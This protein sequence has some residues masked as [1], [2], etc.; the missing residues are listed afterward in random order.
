MHHHVSDVF[1]TG[2]LMALNNDCLRG[3]NKAAVLIVKFLTP[4]WLGLTIRP[5]GGQPLLNMKCKFSSVY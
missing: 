5:N 4:K 1:L 2:M 3:A